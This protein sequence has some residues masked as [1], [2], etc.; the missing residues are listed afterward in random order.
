MNNT[1]VLPAR[2][3]GH[4]E[5][6]AKIEVFLLKQIENDK[7]QCL[8]DVLIKPSKR[9]KPETVIKSVMS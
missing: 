3:I 8:W 5:T 9:V 6:G 1:K 2:L 4:K 7:T